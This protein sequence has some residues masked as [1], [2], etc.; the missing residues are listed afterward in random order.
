MI[1]YTCLNPTIKNASSTDLHYDIENLLHVYDYKYS[2]DSQSSMLRKN[3]AI[4]SL[5]TLEIGKYTRSS[6]L[7]LEANP[8]IFYSEK[9]S[10]LYLHF[11]PIEPWKFE[12]QLPQL[13][14]EVKSTCFSFRSLMLHQ[15]PWKK[16]I[17][18]LSYSTQ[19]IYIS[20]STRVIRKSV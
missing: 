7:K 17:L 4:Q 3:T 11:N 20:N 8:S 14:L 2:F 18:E 15:D 1:W 19:T 13:T 5:D 16:P 12:K 10:W 9:S 6:N